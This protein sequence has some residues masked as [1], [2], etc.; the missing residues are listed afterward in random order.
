MMFVLC[1]VFCI[2]IGEVF[3]FLMCIGEYV[4][5]YFV[6]LLFLLLYLEILEFI[7]LCNCFGNVFVV[8]GFILSWKFRLEGWYKCWE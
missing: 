7:D 6:I 5:Y 2:G 3:F 1:G 8:C 4:V